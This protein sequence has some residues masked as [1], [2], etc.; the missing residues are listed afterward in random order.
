VKGDR[1]KGK[2]T[3]SHDATEKISKTKFLAVYTCSMQFEI[4]AL[5]DRVPKVYKCGQSGDVWERKGPCS[6]WSPSVNTW[7]W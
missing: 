3:S 4:F 5:L 2:K 1:G 7:H 6:T